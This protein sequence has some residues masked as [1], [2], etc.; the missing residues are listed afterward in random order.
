MSPKSLRSHQAQLLGVV[1]SI[2]KREAS[3]LRDVLAAVTPGGGKSLLPVLAARE[4]IGAGLCDRVCWV[5]PRDSLRLQAEEAFADPAWRVALGHALS[6]RAAENG[7]DPCRGLAGYVTTYQGVAAAPELHLAEFQRHRYLL[8]VDEVHHLPAL[9]AND[10]AGGGERSIDEATGWSAAIEP[11]LSLASIRLLLSGTLERAD[12]RR[13]LW[14]PYRRGGGGRDEVDIAAPGWAVVGYSRARALAERAVLPVSFGALDGEASWLGPEPEEGGERPRLGP[15]RLRAPAPNEATRP[16]IFTALRTGFA[17]ALLRRAFDATRA[18]RAERRLRRGLAPGEAARGLGK[19]LVVAPD[20]AQAR[21]YLAQLRRWVPPA[22]AE[23]M[24][25]AVS[26]ER[27]AHETLAAFRLTCEPSVLV[28]V[29]MAYEG[30]DAPE[31]AVVAALT[32]VRSRPWLEQMI[33]RATR[34]DPHAGPYEGQRATVFHPDDP[35]FARFRWRM[36]REQGTRAKPPRGPRQPAL[37]LPD[38][39]EDE[40]AEARERHGI[41]PLESNALALRLSTLRPGPDLAAGLAVAREPDRQGDLL[42]PPSVAERRLRTRLS[43]VIAAQAVED[44]ADGVAAAVAP[45]RGT[46]LYHAYNAALKRALGGKG[47]GEMSL[48]ELEAALEWLGRNRIRDHLHLLE[49]DHRF[50][51]RARPRADWRPPVGRPANARPAND[52]G[53]AKSKPLRICAAEVR[54]R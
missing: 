8:V 16:A 44:M 30:L 35:L 10:N 14:L 11:L 47:R 18:L 38:W 40:L 33:A 28:T 31:V 43:E 37:P 34:V 15:H 32:H 13:I 26:E 19:L 24:A 45:P 25:L 27:G 53:K 39:L 12:G 3:G 4:L 29:A 52:K 6:V 42:A 1:Q 50:G 2:A 46:G 20:Q 36:E 7:A 5:V 41:V 48:A 54:R 51:W 23:T 9:A 22:Q 17:E 49:G 21:R